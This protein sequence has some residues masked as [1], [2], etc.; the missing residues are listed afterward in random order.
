M[1]K[2]VFFYILYLQTKKVIDI[3]QI[4][5]ACVLGCPRKIASLLWYTHM[6]LV[7]SVD[8]ATGE[9]TCTAAEASDEPIWKLL[10]CFLTCSYKKASVVHDKI[11]KFNNIKNKWFLYEYPRCK[12]QSDSQ[13]LDAAR[14]KQKF[15]YNLILSNCEHLVTELKMGR[16]V[17]YQVRCRLLVLLLILLV[18]ISVSLTFFPSLIFVYMAVFLYVFFKL[19]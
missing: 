12:C 7:T 4:T 19:Y 2:Y 10:F 3:G 6:L 8:E 16:P 15:Q 11:V 1:I 14:T 17:S 18:L 13:V 9:I 5:A